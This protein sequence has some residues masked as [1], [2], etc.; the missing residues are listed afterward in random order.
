M[1]RNWKLLKCGEMT[2]RWWQQDA[3]KSQSVGPEGVFF[4]A[5]FTP[6]IDTISPT[7][8]IYKKKMG[9]GGQQGALQILNQRGIFYTFTTVAADWWQD[10]QPSD[11]DLSFTE[12]PGEFSWLKPTNVSSLSLGLMSIYRFAWSTISNI[13]TTDILVKIK[14]F[15]AWY[16]NILTLFCLLLQKQNCKKWF[17]TL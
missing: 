3:D 14:G 7:H 10:N 11:L 16:K 13:H 1:K 4:A 17:S 5:G 8:Q 15:E 12:I 9:G 6:H 2:G